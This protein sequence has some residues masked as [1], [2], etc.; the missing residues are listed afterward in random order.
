[1]KRETRDDELVNFKKPGVVLGFNTTKFDME[2]YFE[3]ADKILEHVKQHMT[4]D[5]LVAYML[6][7][8]GHEEPKHVLLVGRYLEDRGYDYL[9]LSI[10]HGLSE[11]GI[12]TTVVGGMRGFVFKLRAA[13]VAAQE[14]DDTSDDPALDPWL[15]GATTA[16][17]ERA[18]L[19]QVRALIPIAGLAW[20]YGFRVNPRVVEHHDSRD[21]HDKSIA[22]RILDG[23]FDLVI[24]TFGVSFIGMEDTSPT[25]MPFWGAVSR[26]LDK[27]RIAFVNANDWVHMDPESGARAQCAHGF[28]FKRELHAT[29]C[30]G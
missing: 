27:S 16:D 21:T 6:R 28:I 7:V 13:D 19:D 20:Q 2:R 11:L 12:N 14:L 24:Y 9:P 17:I 26:T 30:D 15:N 23:E 4:T 29:T 3:I 10:E 1:M 5:A 18:R 22:K 25:S 8:M